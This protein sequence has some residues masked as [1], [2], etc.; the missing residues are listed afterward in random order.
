MRFEHQSEMPV[1][2]ET[3][4]AWHARPG[5]FERLTPP[6]QRVDVLRRC[7]GIDDGDRIDLRVWQGP[8]PTVWKIEHRNHQPGVQFEDHLLCGPF[9]SFRHRHRFEAIDAKRSRL[10]D[11]IDF[12][13]PGGRLTELIVGRWLLGQ[14]RRAF[15]WRH[16]VT[17]EDLAAHAEDE[18]GAKRVAISGATGMIGGRLA[19]LLTTGGHS[20]V[21]MV[22]HGSKPPGFVGGRG[23]RWSWEHGQIDAGGLEGLDAVVHL[24]AEPIMGSWTPGKKQLIRDSR[25]RGTRLIAETL[26]R[27]KKKPRVLVVASAVG[28]YGNRGQ[29]IVDEKDPVGEGFLA[30]VAR[31]W[32]E[33]AEP[34]RRAGVRVVHARI[35]VVM[36]PK[37]GALRAMLPAF[38]MGVAGRL[39]FGNQWWSWIGLD[40][41][42][43]ALHHLVV[44]ESLEGPVNLVAPRA[45]RNREFTATL[46][47]VLRRPAVIPMP[48]GLVRFLFGREQANEVLLASVRAEPTKLSGSGYRYRQPDLEMMLDEVLGA[49]DAR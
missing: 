28:V 33:A 6:W 4:Y 40:D 30:E 19:S 13:M 9:R 31:D 15:A 46:A 35:G 20:V 14:M 8:I 42:A 25:V 44:M 7:G 49:E 18:S 23:V 38:R 41:V 32:E 34:A 21:S 27:L 11:T 26:S 37:G 45:V 43:G 47:G 36:S 39:G 10:V 22:R 3:L 2:A 48:Q 24:A 29:M 12:E 1:S 16:A 17:R 5:A